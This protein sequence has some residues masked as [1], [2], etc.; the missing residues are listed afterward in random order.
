M[1]LLKKDIITF[2]T[3]GLLMIIT[4]CSGM[5]NTLSTKEYSTNLEE[6]IPK[7]EEVVRSVGL[8]V[9]NGEYIAQGAYQITAVEIV[10]RIGNEPVQTMLL[11]VDLSRLENNSVRVKI[12]SPGKRYVMASSGALES[13][14]YRERIFN[15]LNQI[16]EEKSDS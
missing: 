10:N 14:K 4:G 13:N 11:T 16:F 8:E 2:F 12:S 1:I 7:T 5:K 3:L 6:I 9:Q 15:K